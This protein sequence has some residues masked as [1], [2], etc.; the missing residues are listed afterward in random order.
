M[1]LLLLLMTDLQRAI[2]I[3]E[4]CMKGKPPCLRPVPQVA[5]PEAAAAPGQEGHTRRRGRGPEACSP[6]VG[7]LGPA[8]V[9]LGAEG[10][11]SHPPR[12]PS[13][14]HSCRSGLKPWGLQH[15]PVKDTSGAQ[16][17]S[18]DSLSQPSLIFPG[19]GTHSRGHS[20]GW[21]R[22]GLLRLR[23]VLGMWLEVT[24]D[25]GE[26]PVSMGLLKDLRAAG[27]VLV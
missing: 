15:R 3:K 18:P 11:Q 20:P 24:S 27:A 14:T 22:E 25:Q 12:A 2:F 26:W 5:C 21:C 9:H 23:G 10:W 13:P 7:G 4:F 19:S 16:E 1:R 17:S 6:G 8:A